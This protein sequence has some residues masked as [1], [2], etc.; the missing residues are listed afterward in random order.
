MNA[1]IRPPTEASGRDRATLLR[2]AAAAERA[3]EG[4]R[5]AD[6]LL[7]AA[8]LRAAAGDVAA[9]RQQIDG[10]LERAEVEPGYALPSLIDDAHA[11]QRAL[12]RGEAILA[13]SPALPVPASGRNGC[14]GDKPARLVL[15]E[16]GVT[17]RCARPSNGATLL[18]AVARA[19]R[20]AVVWSGDDGTA[21][22]DHHLLS[23]ATGWRQLP[24]AGAAT[25]RH[26]LV[27][28]HLAHQPDRTAERVVVL[29]LAAPETPVLD[30]VIAL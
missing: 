26:P 1:S 6:R 15:D 25:Q 21:Q 28:E 9:A 2:K 13:P 3:S 12:D 8:H 5:R 27:G 4:G 7:L 23:T 17:V 18:A 11:L 24:T 29:V 22:R 16:A 19:D 10:L 20:L 14:C 30:L